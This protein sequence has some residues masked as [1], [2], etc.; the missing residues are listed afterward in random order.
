MK[1][2]LISV[3]ML[4]ALFG[5]LFCVSASAIQNEAS[6]ADYYAVI[7]EVSEKY[8][9]EI[10]FT[11]AE[12]ISSSLDEFRARVEEYALNELAAINYSK[13]IAASFSSTNTNTAVSGA[14]AST[15]VVSKTY[16]GWKIGATASYTWNSTNQFY[17]FT[18]G[19]SVFVKPASILNYNN[20]FEIDSSYSYASDG[21]RTLWVSATG[22]SN[23]YSSDGVV[24]YPNTTYTVDISYTSLSVN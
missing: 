22:T 12:H 13:A 11:P 5:S 20:W 1:N 4:V 7:E 15:E 16:Q 3:F 18:G 6:I 14:R 2:K 24:S 19:S 17:Y 21:G 23:Y 9:I 10:V 8:D